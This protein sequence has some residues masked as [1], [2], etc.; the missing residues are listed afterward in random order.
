MKGESFVD[1]EPELLEKKS[2]KW[3]FLF[4]K[5]GFDVPF[6]ILVMALLTVGLVMLFSASYAYAYYYDGGS[7]HYIKNQLI[8]AGVGLVAMIVCSKINYRILKPLAPILF[9]VS[10]ILLIV[11]FAMPA[12]QGQWH[13]WIYIG[14]IS[15]QP[16][17]IAK[18]TLVIFFAFLAERFGKKIESFKSFLIFMSFLG[19]T[20]VLIILEPHLSGTLIIASLGV[21]TMVVGGIKKRWLVLLIA[22]GCVGLAIYIF[23]FKGIGYVGDR[24][25]GW[26]NKDY[27]PLGARWQTNQS[28]Y[29]IG[30]GGLFGTGIGNS[31]QKF[32]Y[33]SE[34]QNDFIFAIVCE[35]LGFVGACIII[36]LFM[37]LVWRGCVIA[38]RS[39]DKFGMLTAV[40]IVSQ[41]GVQAALNILV[42]TDAVPNTGVSLPFFSA[43][44]TSLVMIM[45]QMGVVLSV[46]RGRSTENVRD[47]VNDKVKS[48]GFRKIL[49]FWS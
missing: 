49:S 7:Y 22:I 25:Q 39:P 11:V 26:L 12:Y 1:R 31:K 3:S 14:S 21:I 24:L 44:G 8:F 32:L 30:S 33:V 10:L 36:L 38:M 18:F 45:A 6:F 13:R 15:F 2:S 5:G 27:D 17:E 34:P 4:V 47:I 40:G 48:P 28:L 29:A 16:S 20:C 46:S 37:A 23:G 43:G 41:V 35:E 42:V 19:V 9:G